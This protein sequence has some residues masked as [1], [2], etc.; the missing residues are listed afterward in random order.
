MIHVITNSRQYAIDKLMSAYGMRAPFAGLNFVTTLSS[1]YAIFPTPLPSTAR[2][3]RRS[4][5]PAPQPA[6]VIWQRGR[7]SDDARAL[8][9]RTRDAFAFNFL[10]DPTN[11]EMDHCNV[12]EA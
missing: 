6:L 4:S 5:H 9:A 3:F 2:Q 8:R 12:E 11:Q 1:L 10:R 7:M